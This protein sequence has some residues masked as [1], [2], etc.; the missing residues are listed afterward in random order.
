MVKC[1]LS[2]MFLFFIFSIITY[3]CLAKAKVTEVIIRQLAECMK[4]KSVETVALLQSIETL[5][6][7]SHDGKTGVSMRVAINGDTVTIESTFEDEQ[8]FLATTWNIHERIG[9]RMEN[10]EHTTCKSFLSQTMHCEPGKPITQQFITT[11]TTDQCVTT[12]PLNQLIAY[13]KIK[14]AN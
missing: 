1:K 5:S 12:M 4:Q 9:L 14:Q 8:L 10:D 3:D 2:L 13:L 6:N 11:K 7:F